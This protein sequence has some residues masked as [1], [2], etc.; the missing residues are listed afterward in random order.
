MNALA[1]LPLPVGA[2][3]ALGAPRG[4]PVATSEARP[5]PTT[6]SAVTRML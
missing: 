1:A 6:L 3:G 2:V 4:V 5:A